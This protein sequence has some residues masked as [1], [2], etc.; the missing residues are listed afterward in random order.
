AIAPKDPAKPLLENP[1][2]Y[3]VAMILLFAIGASGVEI[4][5]R[6]NT[7]ILEDELAKLDTEF[8]TKSA[9][10]RQLESAAQQVTALASSVDTAKVELADLRA[11]EEIVTY[12]QERR[13]E[14][15]IGIM[16]A[17]RGA[18]HPGLIMQSISEAQHLSETFIATAWSVTEVGAQ[19]FVSGLNQ[20]LQ[21][22]GLSIADESV[23][24]ARGPR[25]I[26]G[27]EI[28]LRIA[29]DG[30]KREEATQ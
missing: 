3:R 19:S 13:Q 17:L 23:A 4:Y 15:P 25:G 29:R 20:G 24:R 5:N 11:R 6:A 14:L 26:D 8:D 1:D 27:F 7:A 10:A 16:D 21:P 9:I 30:L 12:L 2:F 22:L 28:K 18:A